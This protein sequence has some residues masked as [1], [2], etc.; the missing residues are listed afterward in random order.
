M[1]TA[2][3]LTLIAVSSLAVIVGSFA[4]GRTAAQQE[5]QA[6]SAIGLD[7]G[8]DAAQTTVTKTTAH[9]SCPLGQL[10]WV[11]TGKE[12]L[13]GRGGTTA[14]AAFRLANP[15][16][17]D[18]TMDPWTT[19]V[20]NPPVWIVAGDQTYYAMVVPDGTWIVFRATFYGCT[21]P[22]PGQQRPKGTGPAPA[23]PVG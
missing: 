10:P 6:V 12:P 11:Q 15:A 16:V 13:A 7:A 14:E 20:P 21:T 9:P 23:G 22:Q 17:S 2:G 8:T 1:L 18:F 5:V 3:A 4:V 19:R